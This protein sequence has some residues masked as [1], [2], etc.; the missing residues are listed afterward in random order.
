MK[1]VEIK[2][3]NKFLLPV[4]VLT[5]VVLVVSTVYIF[6]S[7]KFVDSVLVKIIQ[8]L[9][10]AYVIVIFYRFWKKFGKGPLIVVSQDEIIFNDRSKPR[11]YRW[12]DIN[13]VLI[14][15]KDDGMQYLVLKMKDGKK[16]IGISSLD[17]SPAE[18]KSLVDEYRAA[19]LEFNS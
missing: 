4:T 1:P 14:M 7:D 8:P 2:F 5:F 13:D 16:E 6:T 15:E 11:S 19:H 18:I 17:K 9:V 10:T 12:K 3:Q